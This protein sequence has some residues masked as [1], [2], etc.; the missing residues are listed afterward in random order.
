M[1]INLESNQVYGDSPYLNPSDHPAE[2]NNEIPIEHRCKKCELGWKPIHEDWCFDC[3]ETFLCPECGEEKTGYEDICIKCQ[4]K[5]TKSLEDEMIA[6]ADKAIEIIEN[7][8][9][10]MKG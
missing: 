9:N 3:Q 2:Q 8:K 10:K 6:M 4:E 1:A 7:L 5:K